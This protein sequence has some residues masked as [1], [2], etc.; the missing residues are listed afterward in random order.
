[1][2]MEPRGSSKYKGSDINVVVD[3]CS[4]VPQQNG[5]SLHGVVGSVEKDNLT[6]SAAL[7][8]PQ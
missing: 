8:M 5:S 6:Y 7:L 4:R 1:M 2:G 3:H